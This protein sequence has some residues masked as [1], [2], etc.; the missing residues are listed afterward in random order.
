MT[1]EQPKFINE[2][3]TSSAQT[4]AE[5]RKEANRRY[6]NKCK[7]NN[8]VPKVGTGDVS[9]SSNQVSLLSNN[10]ID[11]IPLRTLQTNSSQMTQ[12]LREKVSTDSSNANRKEYNRQYYATHKAN[13]KRVSNSIPVTQTP[14]DDSMQTLTGDSMPINTVP[15]VTSEVMLETSRGFY[16]FNN[17]L[18]M[19]V[20][21]FYNFCY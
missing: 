10:S 18:F 21:I 1:N 11:R 17:V 2:A 20:Y 13:E 5:K 3:S 16:I 4:F 7:E 12:T 19:K 14:T 8:K 9:Q 6:Y 15:S